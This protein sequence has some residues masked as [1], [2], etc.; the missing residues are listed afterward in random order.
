MV[1]YGAVSANTGFVTAYLIAI[2]LGLVTMALTFMF[3][4]GKNVSTAADAVVADPPEKSFCRELV[5]VVNP[6]SVFRKCYNV[7]SKPR[8]GHG[9][10]ILCLAVLACAP[11]TC[12]PMEGDR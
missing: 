4:K 8:P 12:V 11:L 9:A 10:M 5:D 3:V 6:V 1:V 2:G 7:L